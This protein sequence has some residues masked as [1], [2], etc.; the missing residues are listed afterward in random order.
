MTSSGSSTPAGVITFGMLKCGLV[1]ALAI[2][3]VFLS[4]QQKASSKPAPPISPLRQDVLNGFDGAAGEA[5]ALAK[6]VAEDKYSWRPMEGVRSF[7]EVFVH[8]AGSTLLFCSYA[9]VKQP[10]GPARDLAAVYMKRGFELPEI[11]AAEA[12]ITDKAKIL[13]IMGQSFEQGR[14]LIRNMPA[15]DLEKSVQ[16]FGRPIT[17]QGLLILMGNHLHE[18]LG[19]AIAYARVN[20]IVPPWSQQK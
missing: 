1:L 13:A 14:D 20:H 19:Q 9:G 18:H 17:M 11:F 4:A 12:A 3:P 10:Q 6:A 16:F 15:A 5:L 2:A 7:G 8:M